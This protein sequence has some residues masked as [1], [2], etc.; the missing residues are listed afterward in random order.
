MKIASQ[1]LLLLVL[2]HTSIAASQTLLID[3]TAQEALW[4]HVCPQ[5]ASQVDVAMSK[6]DY[7]ARCKQHMSPC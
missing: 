5:K 7:Y 4:E 6:Q 3:I 1:S 2:L